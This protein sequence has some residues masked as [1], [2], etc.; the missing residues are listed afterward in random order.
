[1]PMAGLEAADEP[2]N[3][4]V[5][6]ARLDI[7]LL[8]CLCALVEEGQV[9]RAANR[10]GIGQPA[11]S[12]ALGRLRRRLGDP[13]LVRSRDGMLPTARARAA[14]AKAQEALV[15]ID[16]A[17][18]DRDAG[19]PLGS[20]R[21]FHLVA[22][23]SLSFALLPPLTAALQRNAPSVELRVTPADVRRTGEILETG[24]CD[25]VIGYPPRVSPS[26]HTSALFRLRLVCIARADHPDIRG[27]IGVDQFLAASHAV[28]GADP[29]PVAMIEQS[30]EKALRD[31]RGSR[32]I[33]LRVPDLHLSVAAVSGSDLIAVV[34]E[35]V[36]AT[37]AAQFRLQIL[38][39]PFELT[40]PQV[41]MI[42]HSRS[43]RDPAHRWL[44]SQIRDITRGWYR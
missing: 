31:L 18:S 11:M 33:A 12:A 13:L 8:R 2:H 9:T 32:R 14:A 41:L 30:V 28:L 4:L 40:D 20:P 29:T 43:H 42:W 16:D 17:L 36:A 1:M 35:R 22:L 10:L 37:F 34:P 3:A 5:N 6:P 15:L 24:D 23:N 21:S 27:R 26:L 19:E 39:P 38:E 7:H 44:R 25:L